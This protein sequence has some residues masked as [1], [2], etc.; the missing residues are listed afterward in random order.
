MQSRVALPEYCSYPAA[1]AYVAVDG[2]R[3]LLEYETVPWAGASTALH[4]RPTQ[5]GMV[6]DQ[7]PS[8]RHE[9]EVVEAGVS[10]YPVLQENETLSPKKPEADVPWAMLMSGHGTGVHEVPLPV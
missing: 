8:A 10:S 4:S 3:L 2:K 1:Q 7:V 5:V 6:T 9:A